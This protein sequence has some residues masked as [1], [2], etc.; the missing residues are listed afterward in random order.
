MSARITF[1]AM[2]IDREHPNSIRDNEQ[3]K[4]KE[5]ILF[6]LYRVSTEL[7]GRGREGGKERT[8]EVRGSEVMRL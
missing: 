5:N 4:E 7:H 8:K 6:T 1:G 3:T 2:N